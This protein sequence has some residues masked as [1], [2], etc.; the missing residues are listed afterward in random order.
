MLVFYHLRCIY[1]GIYYRKKNNGIYILINIM[2]RGCRFPSLL[3]LKI[4]YCIVKL[5]LLTCI[6]NMRPDAISS[7]T[8]QY[9]RK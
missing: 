1:T 2:L 9:T 6:N 5:Y 8:F 3:I 4:A 7:F